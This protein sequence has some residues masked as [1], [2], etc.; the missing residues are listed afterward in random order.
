MIGRFFVVLLLY[1]ARR[2]FWGI[3]LKPLQP[4]EALA[5]FP[6]ECIVMV[7]VQLPGS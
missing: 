4:A 6:R 2:I 1:V 5:H 3:I 7:M